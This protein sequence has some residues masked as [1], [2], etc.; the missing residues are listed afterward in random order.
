MRPGPTERLSVLVRRCGLV[1]GVLA[2]ATS[3]LLASAGAA[4]APKPSVTQVAARLERLQLQAERA[5]ERYN[6]TREALAAHRQELAAARSRV[7]EQRRQLSRVQASL[8]HL[9]AEQYRQGELSA[10]AFMFGD[11]P[12]DYLAGAGLA[13]SL[14]GRS[15]DAATRLK[16]AQ[17][18]LTRDEAT[19]Q[20]QTRTLAATNATLARE[21]STVIGT[22]RKVQD[23]LDALQAD[24]RRAVQRAQQGTAAGVPVGTTCDDV[25]ITAPSAK[26]KAAIDFACQQLGDPYLWA[27]DGPDSWDCS[28]LT[29]KAWAAAGV[30]LP[31]SSAQQATY[32]TRV[33]MSALEPGDLVFRHSPISH[34]GLYLG[35]GLMINAPQSGDVVRIAPIRDLTAATRL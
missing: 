24:Q 13:S 10:V 15:V 9:A 21:R 27:A 32:G 28:G 29:M 3:L 26:A 1:T 30:S 23:V 8:G 11:H 19:A 14:A 34:V 16:A 20:R 5:S 35:D 2:V 6:Q 17:V 4:A 33:S 22:L 12:Q 18:R 31:H 25:S 7:V